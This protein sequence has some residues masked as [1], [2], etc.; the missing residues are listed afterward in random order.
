MLVSAV[1][2]YRT[3]PSSTARILVVDGLV[4]MHTTNEAYP[5]LLNAYW[6][7]AAPKVT[8]A[9]WSEWNLLPD[10]RLVHE[11]RAADAEFARV[12]GGAS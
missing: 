8:P 10:W 9:D 3:T 12:T 5:Q 11:G 2:S 1:L 7:A 4:H 6:T